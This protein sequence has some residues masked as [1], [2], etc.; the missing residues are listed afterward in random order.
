MFDQG[1]TRYRVSRAMNGRKAARMPDESVAAQDG[2]PIVRGGIVA[3]T[4]ADKGA[5]RPEFGMRARPMH[6]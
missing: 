3:R 4:M 6:T 1:M 2:E 5:R